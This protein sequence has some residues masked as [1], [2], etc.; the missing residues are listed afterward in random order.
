M[1]R[2]SYSVY[3]LY[4]SIT[5]PGAV[6]EE[7][8]RFEHIAQARIFCSLLVEP[9]NAPPVMLVDRDSGQV[10]FYAHAGNGEDK[11]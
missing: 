10:S 2:L 1:E 6:A 5:V 7:C 3:V 4:G 9:K 8:A 11:P